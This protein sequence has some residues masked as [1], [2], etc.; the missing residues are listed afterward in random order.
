M[1]DDAYGAWNFVLWL[2]GTPIAGFTEASGIAP[3]IDPIA[4]REGG[5][6]QQVR[7]LPGA[8]TTEPLTLRRGV[9]RAPVLRDW[10]S[11]A[12]TGVID[13]R[14]VTLASRTEK[15]SPPGFTW[16]LEGAW[17]SKF[18]VSLA[19]AGTDETAIE[20]LVLV[21]DTLRRV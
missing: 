1:A 19:P 9:S 11:A 3:Q 7:N 21:Y 5:A 4:Y 15:D 16:V 13:P 8:L 20:T 17:P 2:D 18:A 12:Q 6:A 10:I 14:E